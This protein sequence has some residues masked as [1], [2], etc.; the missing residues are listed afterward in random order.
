MWCLR[1]GD[2][3]VLPGCSNTVFQESEEVSSHLHFQNVLFLERSM[4][5]IQKDQE[6]SASS[7]RD[8]R[9]VY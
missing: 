5:S 3:G 2:A 4:A 7:L 9:T 8:T 6:A 1:Q